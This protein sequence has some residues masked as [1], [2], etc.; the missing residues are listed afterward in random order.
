MPIDLYRSLDPN[1]SVPLSFSP[2]QYRTG[3][4]L[5]L[6]VCKCH[7]TGQTHNGKC[8]EIA[9]CGAKVVAHCMDQHKTSCKRCHEKQTEKTFIALSEVCEAIRQE[10]ES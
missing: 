2:G 4:V 8:C 6:C 10:H 1:L 9:P 7:S 5:F 3:D